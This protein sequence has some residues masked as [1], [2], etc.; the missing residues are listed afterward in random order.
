MYILILNFIE[1][2]VIDKEDEL[3]KSIQKY[4]GWAKDEINPEFI[5]LMNDHD[6]LVGDYLSKLTKYGKPG[7]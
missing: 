3:V 7:I 6:K 5:S 1:K 4:V 2:D